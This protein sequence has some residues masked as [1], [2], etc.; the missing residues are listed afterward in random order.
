M[1]TVCNSSGQ[2]PSC[3]YS[4]AQLQ[5]WQIQRY[6]SCL[7][8]DLDGR[9][10]GWQVK[11]D[12]KKPFG[13]ANNKLIHPKHIPDEATREKRSRGHP[14]TEENYNSSTPRGSEHMRTKTTSSLLCEQASLLSDLFKR[15]WKA[16]HNYEKSS[17][18]CGS[19][20]AGWR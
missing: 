17:S 4:L 7:L 1:L 14:S 5:I 15:P 19:D 16:I 10:N 8:A 9:D 11:A 12:C 2:K 13:D 3:A 18:Q 6:E 20:I